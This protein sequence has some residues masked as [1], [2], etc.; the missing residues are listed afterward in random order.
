[1]LIRCQTISGERDMH[2]YFQQTTPTT[3]TNYE[4]PWEEKKG[5]ILFNALLPTLCHGTKWNI[6]QIA[7]VFRDILF[8]RSL[9]PDLNRDVNLFPRADSTDLATNQTSLLLPLLLRSQL[10][11]RIEQKALLARLSL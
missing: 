11:E 3:T 6:R 4:K 9:V 5:Q 2:R 8:H 10:S 1:M 7:R